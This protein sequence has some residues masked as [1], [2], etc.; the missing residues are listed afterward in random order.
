MIRRDSAP[1]LDNIDYLMLKN[2]PNNAK[3][4]ILDLFNEFWLTK[5]LPNSWREYQV[6]F[7]DKVGKDKVRPI[8]LSSCVGK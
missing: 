1:G 3:K 7:I 5:H 8:A 4:Y 2:L 6:I